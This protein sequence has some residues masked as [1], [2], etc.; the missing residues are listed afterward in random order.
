VV[1]RIHDGARVHLQQL[2]HAVVLQHAR[3]G[4]VGE[5]QAAAVVDP[6]GV[7]RDLDQLA[8]ALLGALE[9]RH[10]VAPLGDVAREGDD[11][12][13]AVQL[14][15]RQRDL[16]GQLRAVR[17]AHDRLEGP[18]PRVRA[19]GVLGLQGGLLLR[20]E[21]LGGG[22]VEDHL[23]GVPE[24]LDALVADVDDARFGRL[25][26]D[27]G[28]ADA[29]GAGRGNEGASEGLDA[30]ALPG[31]LVGVAI[32]HLSGGDDNPIRRSRRG[33]PEGDVILRAFQWGEQAQIG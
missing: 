29:G 17:A 4:G 26:R 20:R 1:L 21:E 18:R 6:H 8:E 3:G 15:G 14:D 33:G 27:Q 2:I 30:F 5:D 25:H 16:D 7:G 19:V 22:L 13:A 24:D 31:D 32:G 28:D 11:A 12:G 10:G 23:A 9:R